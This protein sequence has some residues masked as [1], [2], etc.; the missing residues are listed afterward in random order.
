MMNLLLS[1]P[2]S[3][4]SPSTVIM[5]LVLVPL[6]CPLCHHHHY[7]VVINVI[8][9]V[10]AISSRTTTDT[11]RVH[12]PLASVLACPA[13]N[14]KSS[15]AP[16]PSRRSSEQL[17]RRPTG[18]EEKKAAL[19]G[20]DDCGGDNNSGSGG[21]GAAAPALEESLDA[22]CEDRLRAA[23]AAGHLVSSRK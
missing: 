17:A 10:A 11:G 6:P 21:G 2:F 19:G 12:P 5:W 15:F 7:S 1:L 13:H 4:S 16:Q 9:L 18:Q 14:E 3:F 22:L 8:N 20:S 23:E